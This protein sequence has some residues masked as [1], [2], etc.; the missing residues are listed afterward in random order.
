MPSN[1]A[2]DPQN[3]SLFEKSKLNKDAQGVSVTVTAGATVNLDLILA[4]DCVIAGGTC[5]LAK[6]SAQGD[7]VDFQV[8]H[9]VYG[10]IN[11][12]VTSWF[13]DPDSTLQPVPTSNYPAKL[14]TGLTLRVVYHSTGSSDV[15]IAVN[16]NKEKVLV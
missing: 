15:W 16:Y 2:F 14:F 12:F 10:M 7:T 8:I 5:F 3:I 9:P 13:M 4:D 11:Q 6:G 1:T